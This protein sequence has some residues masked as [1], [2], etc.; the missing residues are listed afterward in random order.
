MR[1]L[2]AEDDPI[3]QELIRSEVDPNYWTTGLD[4]EIRFEC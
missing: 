2:V 1:V 4:R 3:A